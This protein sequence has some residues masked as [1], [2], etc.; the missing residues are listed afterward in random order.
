MFGIISTRCKDRLPEARLEKTASLLFPLAQTRASLMH[1]LAFCVFFKKKQQHHQNNHWITW[2]LGTGIRVSHSRRRPYGL[3]VRALAHMG[4]HTHTY[5]CVILHSAMV[6]EAAVALKACAKR[7]LKL[8]YGSLR[9]P[10]T[11]R[12]SRNDL[13]CLAEPLLGMKPLQAMLTWQKCF[14]IG[15]DRVLTKLQQTDGH[16]LLATVIR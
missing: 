13:S 4:R 2:Y 11:E 6:M 1:C 7:L 5:T 15:W 10:S 14:V 9:R 16:D 12:V 8:P 3:I